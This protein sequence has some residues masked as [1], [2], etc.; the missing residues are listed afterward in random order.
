VSTSAKLPQIRQRCGIADVLIVRHVIEHAYDLPEF[1]RFIKGLVKPGGYIVWEL[2]DCE[3]ALTLGDFT[4]I[5][6]EHIFYFTSGTFKQLMYSSG[7]E[8]IHFESIPYVLENSI[9]A[10]VREAALETIDCNIKIV[11]KEVSRAIGFAKSLVQRRLV[12]RKKLESIR[13]ERGPIAVFGAGHLTVAFISIMEVTD[14]IS[15]VLDD[16]PNKKGLRMPIGALEI[17]GSGELYTGNIGTCLLGLNPQN[18]PKV[19]ASHQQFIERGGVF[20]SIF[21]GSELDIERIL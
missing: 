6:E 21:P 3:R 11:K 1:I 17:K 8:I 7:F 14:L 18:Q 16:N 13:R 4:T 9:I 2:P 5:W 19:I 15:C 20:A 12:I 10:I